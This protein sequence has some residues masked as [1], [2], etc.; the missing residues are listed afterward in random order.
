MG[1]AISQNLMYGLL[2]DPE[3][4]QR[5]SRH[6]K[7]EFKKIKNA[8]PNFFSAVEQQVWNNEWDEELNMV[9]PTFF[10]V[11][12]TGI[13]TM[14]AQDSDSRI[15][16]TTYEEG[17]EHGFGVLLANKGYGSHTTNAEFSAKMSTG[18]TQKEIDEYTQYC[19]P[20][21]DAIGVTDLP[22]LQVVS[23]TA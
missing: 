13:V 10:D 1:Y 17:C 4:S 19:Q 15:H 6:I 5:L 3:Q 18:P 22:S 11:L 21:L 20:L 14:I 12:G 8:T 16:N 2:L 9:V 23:Y 7:M